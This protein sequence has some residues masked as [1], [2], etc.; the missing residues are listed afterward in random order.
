MKIRHQLR[1]QHG[2]GAGNSPQLDSACHPGADIRNLPEGAIHHAQNM[3]YPGIQKLPRIR[4]PYPPAAPLKKL[5]PQA[6]LQLLHLT[7][8]GRLG[9]TQPD[10]RMADISFLNNGIKS[11]HI[12][13]FHI[14][15][16][17]I[18]KY[19]DILIFPIPL[20]YYLQKKT[21]TICIENILLLSHKIKPPVSP[22]GGFHL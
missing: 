15:P 20:F 21:A 2:T 14:V 7:A 4:K 10:S 1:N 18:H 3:L 19:Y 11:L 5:H 12:L 8:Q 6:G 13:Y 9:N 16:P 17:L 22:T